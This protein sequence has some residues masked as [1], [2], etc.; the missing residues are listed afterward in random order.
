MKVEDVLGPKVSLALGRMEELD[1]MERYI[2]QLTTRVVNILETVESKAFYKMIAVLNDA[3]QEAFVWKVEVKH[4]RGEK[5]RAFAIITLYR[6]LDQEGNP[7]KTELYS[8]QTKN[9][10]PSHVLVVASA[11]RYLWGGI[12]NDEFPLC[13]NVRERLAPYLGDS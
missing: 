1:T 9:I 13:Q 11:L 2:V 3:K 4:I 6:I 5:V 7:E 10:D 12:Q 8:T